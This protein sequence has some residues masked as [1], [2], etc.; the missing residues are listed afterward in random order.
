[1]A[2]PVV[3]SARLEGRPLVA[4]DDVLLHAW[5]ADPRVSATMAGVR[6]PEETAATTARLAAD[7]EA[8]GLGLHLWRERASGAPV[9]R[10]GLRV[11]E[12]EGERVVEAA[13]LVNP[14][15]WGEGFATELASAAIVAAREVRDLPVILAWTLPQNT[16][17]RRVM[18]KLGMRYTRDATHAGLEHVVYVLA[19]RGYTPA[20]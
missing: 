20:R 7:W 17:S 9:A 13:W 4:E 11:G 10:G 3:R 12:L 6:T 2:W 18:E 15:R 1:M 19:D 14:D 8:E 16:A 5:D